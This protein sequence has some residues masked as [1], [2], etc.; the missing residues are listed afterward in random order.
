MSNDYKGLQLTRNVGDR[1]CIYDKSTEQKIYLTIVEVK[2]VR[3]RIGLDAPENYNIRRTEILHE[4]KK[5]GLQNE[6]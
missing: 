3:T 5:R 4:D 6:D 1:I 2:G